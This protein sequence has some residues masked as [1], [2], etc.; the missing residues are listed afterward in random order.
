MLENRS[1]LAKTTWYMD[2]VLWQSRVMSGEESNEGGYCDSELDK[3][4]SSII[5]PALPYH[6]RAIIKPVELLANAGSPNYKVDLENPAIRYLYIPSTAEIGYETGAATYNAEVAS[7]ANEIAFSRYNGYAS[8]VK[9]NNN[10]ADTA[11][12]YWTRSAETGSTTKYKHVSSNGYDGSTD[13]S[14][15]RFVCFGFSI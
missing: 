7:E 10:N 9:K 14:R 4:L 8:R 13:A 15:D 5:Y 1:G 11:Q 2:G 12:Y 3:W 6:W